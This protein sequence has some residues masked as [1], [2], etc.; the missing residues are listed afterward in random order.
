M[1]ATLQ[2]EDVVALL[3]VL[4]LLFADALLLPFFP[5]PL[6]EDVVGLE[7]E[8]ADVVESVAV[9]TEDVSP[10]LPSPNI[11][12]VASN[13]LQYLPLFQSTEIDLCQTTM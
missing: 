13:S 1:F 5:F 2:V 6:E 4:V 9:P 3:V 11:Q 10:S 7:V 8:D 12:I